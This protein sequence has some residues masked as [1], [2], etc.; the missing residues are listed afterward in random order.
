VA[1]SAKAVAPVLVR[2]VPTS[3]VAVGAAADLAALASDKPEEPSLRDLREPLVDLG[4]RLQPILKLAPGQEAPILGAK[5][6]GLGN[7]VVTLL[8]TYGC[9]GLL[10]LGLLLDRKGLG[11]AVRF[12]G[13]GSVYVG[14]RRLLISSIKT[15][16]ERR[17]R[18]E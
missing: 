17:R 4:F 8:R 10:C 1:S 14:H 7:P 5:V 11:F 13:S 18:A 3:K 16:L 2:A 9:R 12:L 15:W 6:R